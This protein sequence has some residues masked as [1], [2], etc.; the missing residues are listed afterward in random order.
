MSRLCSCGART[1]GRQNFWGL[2]GGGGVNR[3]ISLEYVLIR[4]TIAVM[5]FYS[6]KKIEEERIYFT[7]S[8]TIQFTINSSEGR[9]S[10]RT[11]T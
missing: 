1:F 9:D 2:G 10:H 4:V 6:Q 3:D 8:S 7:H 11:G 5:K